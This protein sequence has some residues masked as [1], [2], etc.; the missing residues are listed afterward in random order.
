VK[1]LAKAHQNV[2]RQRQDFHHKAALALVREND[3]IYYEDLQTA[4][5]LKNHALAKRAFP[6]RRGQRSWAS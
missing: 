3:T 4:S 6:M 5:L 2:K 1:L